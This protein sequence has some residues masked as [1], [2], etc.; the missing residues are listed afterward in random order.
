MSDEKFPE[1]LFGYD[2]P[3]PRFAVNDIA[4]M[5][6]RAGV[7]YPTASAR[8]R[9]FAANRFIHTREKGGGA[10]SPR[11]FGLSDVAT[12]KI[13]SNLQDCGVQDHDVL[14]AASLGCYAWP[15]SAED[16]RLL[17]ELAA[18]RGT[19]SA[20]KPQ[21][22]TPDAD[23][24]RDPISAAIIGVARGEWWVFE[25]DVLRNDQTGE[26]T[27]D[28]ALYQLGGPKAYTMGISDSDD[29]SSPWIPIASFSSVIN[30]QFLPILANRS[31]QH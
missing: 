9:S 17:R 19:R 29:P 28:T 22:K 27:F 20:V 12:A 1:P 10:T 4:N 25:L 16:R 5:F 11:L 26:R 14:R 7:P 23:R 30:P 31:G 24:P 15:A 18:G 21:S 2:E 8:I 6:A 13:L 3:G